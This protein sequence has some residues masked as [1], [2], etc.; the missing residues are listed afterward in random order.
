MKKRQEKR[1]ES[2]ELRKEIEQ[3]DN[4]FVLGFEKLTVG[5]DFQLRKSVRSAG[6]RYKVVKNTL[7][8]KASQGTKSEE[9]MK[10]LA[11]MTS[12]AY[13]ASDPVALAKALT[14]YA[15]ENPTFRFKAGLVEGR[16]I[17]IS[18]IS[19][20]ASLPSREEMFGKLL[21]LIQAPAQRLVTAINGVGRNVAVVV[22]QACKENK[23]TA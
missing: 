8:A 11:G 23:F 9:V 3:V 18:A 13:T 6:G 2:E 22:D 7:A 5:R 12:V 10:D 1:K 16:A 17:D 20:L 19:E 14:A 21:Y 4:L 15:K